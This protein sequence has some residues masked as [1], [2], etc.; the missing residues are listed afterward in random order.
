[1][2]R[3]AKL[4]VYVACVCVH[5][6]YLFHPWNRPNVPLTLAPIYLTPPPLL[7]FTFLSGRP[8][9]VD[10]YQSSREGEKKRGKTSYP[11]SSAP[12][13]PPPAAAISPLIQKFGPPE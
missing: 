1:M 4:V 2:P 12:T 10:A 9:R 7:P 8:R 6:L 3:P 5:V 13:P 11:P